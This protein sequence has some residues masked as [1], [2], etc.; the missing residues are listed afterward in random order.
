M[1]TEAT[2]SPEMTHLTMSIFSGSTGGNGSGLMT[3]AALLFKA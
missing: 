1:N 2:T 3:T